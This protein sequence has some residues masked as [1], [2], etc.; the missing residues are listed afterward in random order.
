MTRYCS[1]CKSGENTIDA[2]YLV[3]GKIYSSSGRSI[4]Y[5]AYLCREHLDMLRSDDADLT[6][7]DWVSDSALDE[8]TAE[9]TSYSTFARLCKNNPTLRSYP[10]ESSHKIW[11]LRQ[12]YKKRMGSH[13]A[14]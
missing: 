11:A 1:Q 6:I 3:K 2:D 5:R 8:L 13:P 10:G 9:L 14:S 7:I 4:P 12:A